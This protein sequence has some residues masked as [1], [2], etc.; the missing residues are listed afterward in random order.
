MTPP[1]LALFE[2]SCQL[3]YL[4]VQSSTSQE[5]HTKWQL[6]LIRLLARQL[7]Y[8]IC[9]SRHRDCAQIQHIATVSEFTQYRVLLD[10]VRE[11]LLRGPM[12]WRGRYDD[13]VDASPGIPKH[14]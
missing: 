6:A 3:Q 13:D 7:L 2:P 9:P 1:L 12:C 10:R 4:G 5:G 8:R 14:L 11:H